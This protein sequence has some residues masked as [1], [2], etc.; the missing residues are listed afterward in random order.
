MK[1]VKPIASFSGINVNDLYMGF[2][3]FLPIVLGSLAPVFPWPVLADLR[4]SLC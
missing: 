2:L 3:G 1:G 4:W